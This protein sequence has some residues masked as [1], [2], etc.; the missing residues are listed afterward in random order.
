MASNFDRALDE[1]AVFRDLDPRDRAVIARTC[2]WHRYAAND[3]VVGHQE[4]SSD[5]YFVIQGHLRA[6]I[7]PVSGRAVTYTDI[8]PG[9]LFGEFA[10]IDGAARSADVYALDDA[11]VGAMP[12]AAFNKVLEDHPAVAKALFRRLIHIIRDL[13]ERVFEF[14]ALNVNSRIHAELLRRAYAAGVDGNTARIEPVPTHAEIA[15]R[16]STTRE[17]VTRELSAMARS[18]ALSREKDALIVNDV[19]GLHEALIQEAGEISL[20]SEA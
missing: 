14:T 15:A 16:V 4:S 11:F 18:G 2:H 9:E 3:Q 5:V 1:V 10:A 8:G 6:R 17:A 19:A 12:A 7:A 13:N 20:T